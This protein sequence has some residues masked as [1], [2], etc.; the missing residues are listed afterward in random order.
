MSDIHEYAYQI[1]DG[2]DVPRDKPTPNEYG[3]LLSNLYLLRAATQGV[4]PPHEPETL[5]RLWGEFMEHMMFP[6]DCPAPKGLFARPLDEMVH[7]KYIMTAIEEIY[8]VHS[9]D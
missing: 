1:L 9:A 2:I 4:Q 7:Y 3:R 5:E 6:H 8:N